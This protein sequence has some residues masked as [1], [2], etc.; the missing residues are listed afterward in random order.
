MGKSTISIAIFHCYV[1]SPEANPASASCE[2]L[3]YFPKITRAKCRASSQDDGQIQAMAP[4]SPETSSPAATATWL[5]DHTS[6]QPQ[7]C[8]EPG[9]RWVFSLNRINIISGM[10]SGEPSVPHIKKVQSNAHGF[11]CISQSV[12]GKSSMKCTQA[13][14]SISMGNSGS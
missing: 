4:D 1:S 8:H 5:G 13:Y 14:F 9:F 11:L 10:A 6:N 2:V 12:H 3:L 7:E